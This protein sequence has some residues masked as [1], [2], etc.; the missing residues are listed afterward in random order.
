[1][2]CPAPVL[3]CIGKQ[4]RLAS[5][6]ALLSRHRTRLLLLK[7]LADYLALTAITWPPPSG[8]PYNA[9]PGSPASMTPTW[10][11]PLPSWLPH[12]VRHLGAVLLVLVQRRLRFPHTWHR[13]C[14]RFGLHLLHFG[15]WEPTMMQVR[16]WHVVWLP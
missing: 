14:R 8:D 10:P 16:G 6:L 7:G 12:P 5:L 3:R 2:A 9:G 15:V 13:L 1:M 11:S 4:P